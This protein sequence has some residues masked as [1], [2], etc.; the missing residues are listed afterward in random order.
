MVI[1]NVKNDRAL[2]Q[3]IDLFVVCIRIQIIALR[4]DY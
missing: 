3:I 4:E 1:Y 2:K